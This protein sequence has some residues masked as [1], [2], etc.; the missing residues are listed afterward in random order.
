M[1]IKTLMSPEEE[2]M[3]LLIKNLE[4]MIYNIIHNTYYYTYVYK[5]FAHFK[6]NHSNFKQDILVRN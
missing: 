3:T 4:T 5:F 1:F 6:R 2:R